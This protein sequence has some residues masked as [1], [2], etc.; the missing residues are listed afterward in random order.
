M[1]K[2]DLGGKNEVKEVVEATSKLGAPK[3]VTNI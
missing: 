3:P 2:H 1:R